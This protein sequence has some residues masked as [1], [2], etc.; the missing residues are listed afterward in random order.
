MEEHQKRKRS[1]RST[2]LTANRR[3]VSVLLLLV[4][5]A[6][7]VL[8][9]IT[10]DKV[11]SEE[12]NRN[13]AQRPSITV[14]S[15]LDGSFFSAYSSYLS[16]QFF[17]RDTWISL[18]TLF[19]R[20]LGKHDVNGIYIGPNKRLFSSPELPDQM[21]QARKIAA[22]NE[23]A[24]RHDDWNIM[25]MLVPD[26]ASIL[27]DRL[28]KNAPVRDQKADIY[29]VEKNLTSSIKVIDV[30]PMFFDHADE[31]LYYRSDHHWTSLGAYYA[32][33]QAT[34]YMDMDVPTPSFEFLRVSDSF[35][36][37]LASQS[38]VHATDS[39]YVCLPQGTDTSY[40]VN[41]LDT[42]TRVTAIFSTAALE[43][44]D[45]YT[46]FFGGNHPIVE[47]WTTANNGRN[48]LLFKDSY[49]N[50]FVQFL[51]TYYDKIIMIDPRYFYSDLGTTIGTYGITDV[52]FLYSGDTWM[53]DTSL[54]D[55]LE[56]G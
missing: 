39:I 20:M 2:R 46:V 6:F 49:A 36:G 37:T 40:Y 56:T 12:E 21:V 29:S 25:F 27:T 4:I 47:I 42:Q 28:P 52:L 54:A 18:D 55:V 1:K 31:V 38:G 41:Y 43:E 15:I 24:E 44:K 35:S 14:D 7:A 51:T 11:F 17:G 45:Q 5:V 8:G 34:Q 26:A 30:A 22:V 9:L 13:L 33:I 50:S 10:R 16:D 19:T 53:T 23:F 48:L 3:A 32:F